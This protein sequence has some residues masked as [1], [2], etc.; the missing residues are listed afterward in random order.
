VVVGADAASGLL[1]VDAPEAL[2]QTG[3]DHFPGV[4]RRHPVGGAGLHGDGPSADP[5]PVI[6]ADGLQALVVSVPS[7]MIDVEPRRPLRHV[8]GGKEKQFSGSKN[9]LVWSWFFTC[10][11]HMSQNH[12][13]VRGRGTEGMGYTL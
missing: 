11:G 6:E 10:N 1:V 3:V 8:W 9:N 12:E 7:G 13:E 5:L 4:C 2:L